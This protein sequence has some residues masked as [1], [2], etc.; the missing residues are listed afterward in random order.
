[1]NE[2]RKLFAFPFSKYHKNYFLI[3]TN[4]NSKISAK[5]TNNKTRTAKTKYLQYLCELTYVY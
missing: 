4:A 3:K 1:M 2:K 5:H